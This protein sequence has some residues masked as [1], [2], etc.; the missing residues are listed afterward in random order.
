MTYTQTIRSDLFG[1]PEGTVYF[2]S[3]HYQTHLSK[4]IPSDIFYK[5]LERMVASNDL[6]KLAKGIYYRP[7]QSKYGVIPPS[8]E[9]IIKTFIEQES[10]GMEVGYGLYNRLGLSTQIAKVRSF[11]LNERSFESKNVMNLTFHSVPLKFDEPVKD[12]VALL[13]VL[14]DYASIQNLDK[15][16]FHRFLA[17]TIR[18]YRDEVLDEILRAKRYRPSVL[19]FYR[20]VLNEYSVQNEIIKYLSP[21]SDYHIPDW[22]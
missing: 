9:N 4:T 12:Q 8:E 22:R 16:A 18:D 15:N 19:A 20:D 10:D 5:T 17:E 13:E 6:G 3:R 11:F 2:A 1:H 7:I 14:Q 21:S